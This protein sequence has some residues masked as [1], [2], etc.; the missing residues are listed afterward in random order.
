[1]ILIVNLLGYLADAAI[2]GAYFAAVHTASKVQWFHWANAIG[3]VPL[4]A[5]ESLT[6]AWAVLPLTV[7][8]GVLGWIGALR[9]QTGVTATCECGEY[10][11][12]GGA[13]RP[14]RHYGARDA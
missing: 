11:L 1:V 5:V 6:G 13:S 10:A 3:A 12:H 7:A 2:I 4:V 14:S 8:F 9:P